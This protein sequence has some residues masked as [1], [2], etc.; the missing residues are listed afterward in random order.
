MSHPSQPLEVFPPPSGFRSPITSVRREGTYGFYGPASTPRLAVSASDFILKHCTADKDGL[1]RALS[2]FLDHAAAHARQHASSTDQDSITH[3]TW[4]CVRITAPTDAWS[5]PRW[6][7][8]GR[9]FGCVCASP[10][11]HAKYAMT[12]LGPPTRMLWPEETVDAAVSKVEA[13]YRGLGKG[14]ND[15]N[16]E[17]EE[18][19]RADLAEALEGIPL[20]EL[21]A[22]QIVRFT[23]GESDAPVHSEPDSSAEARLFVSVMFGSE[24]ELRDMCSIR[25]EVYGQEST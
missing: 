16:Y 18:K 1:V 8:D 25:D 20:V 10:R 15:Y 13:Q 23:W 5:V 12:L 4:L 22:G 3:S 24:A 14:E 11:P 9:M 6:H 19:E 21:H 7:R 17:S 2:S